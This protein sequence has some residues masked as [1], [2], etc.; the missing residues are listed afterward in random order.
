MDS[1]DAVDRKNNRWIN[2]LAASKN[3]TAELHRDIHVHLDKNCKGHATLGGE[4]YRAVLGKVGLYTIR[5]SLQVRL[6]ISKHMRP[7]KAD[8]ARRTNHMLSVCA[9]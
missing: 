1:L 2:V 5:K 9:D 4:V 6:H 3:T 8:T 7:F